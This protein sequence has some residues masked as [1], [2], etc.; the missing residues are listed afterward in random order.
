MGNDVLINKAAIIERCLA[1]VEEEYVGHENELEK[2][3][4]RQDSIILNIQ[5]ACEATIDVAMHIVRVKKLGVPQES[6]EA[7]QMLQ[8]ARLIDEDLKSR[9][10]AMVGFRNVAVHDY[11]ALNLKIV[12]HILEH[13][14]NDFREFVKILLLNSSTLNE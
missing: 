3:F 7:F 13:R 2:N 6:R 8:D 5:R 14:L 1:R 4:T 10:Q 11:R 12:R 9:L